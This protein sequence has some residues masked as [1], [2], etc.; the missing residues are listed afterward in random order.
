MISD[1]SNH[2]RQDID[3][4]ARCGESEAPYAYLADAQHYCVRCARVLLVVDRVQPAGR[5]TDD[6]SY[7][8][9]LFM[10]LPTD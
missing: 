1:S 2:P 6:L 4:C 8:D 7:E 5:R 3:G 10:E 9:V